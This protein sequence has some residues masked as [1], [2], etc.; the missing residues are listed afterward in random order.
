MSAI[1]SCRDHGS[2]KPKPPDPFCH[3][4]LWQTIDSWLGTRRPEPLSIEK[5]YC[6]YYPRMDEMPWGREGYTPDICIDLAARRP[7]Q[8]LT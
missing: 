3:D 4:G 7:L 1:V 6:Y 5:N 2:D 8:H